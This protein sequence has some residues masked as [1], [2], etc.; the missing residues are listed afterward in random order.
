MIR[1]VLG[2]AG[3]A[4]FGWWLWTGPV[5]D[6]RNVPHDEALRFNAQDMARCMESRE[7]AA[8]LTAA[9]RTDPQSACARKYGLYQSEGRWLAANPPRD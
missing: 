8:T 1:D 4:V 2:Y 3:F 5:H 6:M 7:F 9:L